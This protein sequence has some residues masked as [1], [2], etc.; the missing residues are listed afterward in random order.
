VSIRL[1]DELHEELR[2]LAAV[3]GVSLQRLVVDALE[4]EAEHQRTDPAT[5][6]ALARVR[7]AR[8]GS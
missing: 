2:L 7:A 5:A 8:E 4:R 1:P 6:A 3:Q